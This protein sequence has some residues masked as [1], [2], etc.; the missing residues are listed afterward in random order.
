[1]KLLDA[2]ALLRYVLNDISEQSDVVANAISEG[3]STTPEAIAEVV[4]VLDGVY[5]M[6]REEISWVIHCV[7]LDVRV[8]DVRCLRYAV[9]VY[10][11]TK[12]DFVDCL[13]IAYRKVLGLEILSFDRKLN[14]TLNRD[15]Q[16]FQPENPFKNQH[17]S[18]Q[19]RSDELHDRTSEL[20]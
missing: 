8:E 5:G 19:Q 14:S 2:N 11:L 15:L 3:C 6:P 18:L 10:N 9:G 16:V 17:S 13:L 7:L 12:L 20:H 4:Y 1:M